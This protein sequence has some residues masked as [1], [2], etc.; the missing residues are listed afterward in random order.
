MN[1]L[2]KIIFLFFLFSCASRK[3]SSNYNLYNLYSLNNR[4]KI[5]VF[6][7]GEDSSLLCIQLNSDNFIRKLGWIKF[8]IGIDLK[9][10]HTNTENL[11]NISKSV[12]WLVGEKSIRD[13]VISIPIKI[14]MGVNNLC[15]VNL[16]DLNRGLG[17]TVPYQIIKLNKNGTQ[18]F[19]I[20]DE[21]GNRLFNNYAIIGEKI[22]IQYADS[23]KPLAGYYFNR[24]YLNSGPP[25]FKSMGELIDFNPDST[26]IVNAG[27][28]IVLD[29][30]G[31]YFFELENGKKEGIAL[32][33][34]EKEFP[35]IETID[36]LIEPLVYIC[37]RKEYL[38]LRGA[39]DRR[40][41]FDNFWL[42]AAG[43][44]KERAK[45]LIQKFYGRVEYVNAHFA[46]YKEGWKTDKGMIFI[47]Y[48]EPESVFLDEQSEVWDYSNLGGQGV[49]RFKFNLGK[50]VFSETDYILERDIMY[51]LPWY[52]AVEAWRQGIIRK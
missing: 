24:S 28:Q 52:Q 34:F 50:N 19:E 15:Y 43:N 47:L 30:R 11:G 17:F 41:L 25:F 5:K 39:I 1:K 37:E 32:S 21:K 23:L 18:F 26:F 45:I 20:F 3:E 14:P 40:I 35:N 12:E 27:E 49:L 48:G 4:T 6:H 10:I 16:F 44:N 46:S 38:E 9:S 7:K 8:R 31:I 33:V 29:K 42:E 36:K 2:I 13:T 22:K 51:Q